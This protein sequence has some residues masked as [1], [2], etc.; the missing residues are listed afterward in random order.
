MI[1]I[2]VSS[3]YAITSFFQWGK[4]EGLE[5]DLFWGTLF[6]VGSSITLSFAI[7]I[8]L[9]VRERMHPI[10]TILVAGVIIGMIAEL[11]YYY[12][13]TFEAFYS[14]HVVNT[15]WISSFLLIVFTLIKYNNLEKSKSV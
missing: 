9:K 13:E 2:I 8:G 12:L 3:F 11:W 14:S 5:F 7:I 4:Y 6:T 15:V 10:W 1:P